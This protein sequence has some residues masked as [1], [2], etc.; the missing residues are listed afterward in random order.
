MRTVMKK[1]C[2]LVGLLGVFLG[3]PA[4]AVPID[5]GMESASNQ[6]LRVTVYADDGFSQASSSV[7]VFGFNSRI[8]GD[9]SGIISP[10]LTLDSIEFSFDNLSLGFNIGAS[11]VPVSLSL[12]GS[13]GW[14]EISG[15]SAILGT[16]DAFL[17]PNTLS[18]H[19]LDLSGS[20]D[21]P[22]GLL[23]FDVSG[24]SG[25]ATMTGCIHQL[26]SQPSGP[27]FPNTYSGSSCYPQ[28]SFT[29]LTHASLLGYDSEPLGAQLL[30]ASNAGFKQSIGTVGG[31]A[32]SVGVNPAYQSP[33]YT[34][35]PNTALLLG[36]GLVG[37]G[38]KRRRRQA[39]LH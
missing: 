17:V 24:V 12:G 10:V 23:P 2:L 6:V 32:W 5:W 11:N 16:T 37:L 13:V 22:F 38:I 18:G 35:E 25:N 28:L 20:L 14:R 19:L 39:V 21:T 26:P 4:V 34:P 1:I 31:V 15:A 27:G 29:D 3:A 8:T 36:F 30:G 33:T 9:V 7:D